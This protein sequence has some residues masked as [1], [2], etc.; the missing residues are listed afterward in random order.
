[1][2]KE[3]GKK[4]ENTV[5]GGNIEQAGLETVSGIV[6][7]VVYSN[8]ENGY[9][10]CEVASVGSDGEDILVTLVG[11]MP[12]I[13]VSETVKACGKWVVHPSFGKQ[14]SVEFYEKELPANETAILRYLSSRTVKGIGPS[15]AKKIVERFGQ[16]TFDVLENHPQWLEEI[17]GISPEKAEKIS[18]SF[19]QQFGVRSVMMFCRDFVGPAT[20]V[21]IYKR[22]G[23]AAVDTIKDNPY[24]LCDE[25]YGLGFERVDRMAA[26]LGLEN[27]SEHRIMAGMKYLLNYN[28]GSN[29]HTYIPAERLIEAS[30]RL[31]SVGEDEVRN[32]FKALETSEDIK[33]VR[34]EGRDLTYLKS[35][36]DAERYT[37]EKLDLLDRVCP[38]L[39]IDDI[40]RF[41]GIVE[42]TNGISYA[43]AQK[44]AIVNVLT[45]GV[46]ILTGGPG[47][48]KTT[49]IRA[50]ISL[51]ENMRMKVLL[52]APTGRAAKRM[53]ES[54][55]HEASTIHRMLE[56]EYSDGREPIYKK[57]E[58]DLLDADVIIIDEA[59]MIDIVL[60]AALCKAIKPA[61]RLLLIGDSDQLPSVG[62][63]NV[64]ND[65]IR[66]DR[67][68]TVRLREIFRQV[69][70][71]LIITNAHAINNGDY[72]DL[73]IKNNDF[74]FLG[75]S[76][77]T[78][79]ADTVASLCRT[80]LPRAYGEQI[81]G[82]I[83]V[84]VPSR[85]GQVGTQYLNAVLQ[86]S[87]N[88]PDQ[89]K[90][91]KKY[92]DIIFR[93]GDKVMQIRNNYE[94]D[95]ERVEI[96]GDVTEGTGIFNGDIGIIEQIRPGEESVVVNFEGRIAVYDYTQLEEL[97]H[98]YAITVHK[99]QGSEYPVVIIPL[100]QSSPRLMTRNLLYTAV[101]RAREMV[102]IVGEKE[103]VAQMV[104]NNRL[105]HRYTGLCE[106]LLE[107]DAM[108]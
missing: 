68:N 87:L 98:A 91:E 25:I 66:S 100:Y 103:T 82:K 22:W 17:P 61:A 46:M 97:E 50:V 37:A 64:L 8:E 93:E 102:I 6:E 5:V 92:R 39:D 81:R 96:T 101:T 79:I 86:S 51:F 75:R 59:S 33:V 45:S 34:R 42:S 58:N 85:K 29:G 30:M 43:K 70:S 1:M 27:N 52:A 83:Q 23:G 60:M 49:V 47:T 2:D 26:S 31:L 65:I 106:A 14:F 105:S 69:S 55:D 12:F 74:F 95:W 10:V 44:K 7:R 32:A 35:Y 15:S 28:A 71:S 99:S 90:R 72:P 73:D 24:I 89:K 57:N 104:Q 53:S 54:T 41:I 4:F 48:G 11:T 78:D 63:G 19:E 76:S 80:R 3:N 13:A 77:G 84:I 38:K 94:I 16:D 9:T 107:I 67:F 56:M 88:P 20:A 21:R 108:A 18:E 36:Y 40:D 62:A